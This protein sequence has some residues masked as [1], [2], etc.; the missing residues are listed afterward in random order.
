MNMKLIDLL[1]V[2]P[3]YE[4]IELV[5]EDGKS[6]D[7]DRW[8]EWG[9]GDRKVENIMTDLDMETGFSFLIVKIEGNII[10]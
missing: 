3:P 7:R 5:A 6:L 2:I 4:Q 1:A 9:L 10:D 8:I